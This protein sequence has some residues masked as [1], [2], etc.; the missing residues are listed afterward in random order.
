[1]D[2]AVRERNESIALE[3]I[4]HALI[5]QVHDDADVAAVVEAIPEMDASI[6]VLL[7][8]GLEGG[9]DTEFN[10]G[11]IPVLLN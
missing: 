7:I 3:E 4:K 8:V 2:L 6:P 11:C 5:E 10:P 1:L 9:Q